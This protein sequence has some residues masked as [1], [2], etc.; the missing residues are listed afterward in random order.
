MRRNV[1]DTL[2]RGFDN[3]LANWQ[4]SLI[5]LGETLL[6]TAVAVGGVLLMLLP[7]LTSIGLALTDLTTPDA[8]EDALQ[9][10][11]QKGMIFVWFF[12]LITVLLI[13]F[14][15]LHSFVEAGCARI[16]VDADRAAGPALTGPRSRY[17]AFSMNRW[18][19]GAKDGFWEV[20]WIYNAIW[21]AAGLVMLIP[22]VPM[23]VILFMLR[24]HEGAAVIFGCLGLIIVVLIVMV[25]AV[26]TGMWA[27]RSIVEWAL[28]RTGIGESIAAGWRYAIRAD[29]GRHLL[30]TLA[31]IVAAIAGSMAFASFSMIAGFGEA[32]SRNNAAFNI[33]TIPLR[34]AGT[35]LNWALSAF[36]ATWYLAS[37]AALGVE[38]RS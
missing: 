5:R 24:G 18:I 7:I 35:F 31:I 30:I 19:D 3:A 9:A 16:I 8:I 26:V 29:L 27:N 10:M 25:M 21:A 32:V 20:F 13:V 6:F 28:H 12:L 33:V 14:A 23:A 34:L 38:G 15:V 2:R 22:L 11:F 4:L 36:I 1:I 17:N 37:Y